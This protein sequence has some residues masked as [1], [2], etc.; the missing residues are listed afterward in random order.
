MCKGFDSCDSCKD[1]KMLY[2]RIEKY[3]GSLKEFFP[4]LEP[5]YESSNKY[6]FDA[7]TKTTNQVIRLRCPCCDIVDSVR[8]RRFSS[9]KYKCSSCGFVVSSSVGR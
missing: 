7:I 4:E 8:S 1:L 2:S 3:G 9:G 6:P 5:L